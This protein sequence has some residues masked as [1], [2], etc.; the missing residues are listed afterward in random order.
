[1]D[2]INKYYIL[3]IS[4]GIIRKRLFSQCVCASNSDCY[5]W[6]EKRRGLCKVAQPK[7]VHSP[8]AKD[9][10]SVFRTHTFHVHL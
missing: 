1:M 9:M 4:L 2:A 5:L 10:S 8:L 7:S 3:E 6:L